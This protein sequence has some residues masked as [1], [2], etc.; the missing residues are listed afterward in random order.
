MKTQVIYSYFWD[1]QIKNYYESV[2]IFKNLKDEFFFG[3]FN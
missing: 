3:I 2:A 1:P